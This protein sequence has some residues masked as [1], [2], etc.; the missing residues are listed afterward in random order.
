M[1]G[2]AH[3]QVYEEA[4]LTRSQLVPMYAIEEGVVLD[5]LYTVVSETRLKVCKQP[6]ACSS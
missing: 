3:I 1:S 6:G 4:L 2:K 5:L